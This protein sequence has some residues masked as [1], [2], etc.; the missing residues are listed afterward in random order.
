M[1]GRT[2]TPW[3][4]KGVAVAGYTAA[5]VREYPESVHPCWTYVL[6]RN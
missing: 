3:E 2:P 4:M 1:A 6:M 5:T